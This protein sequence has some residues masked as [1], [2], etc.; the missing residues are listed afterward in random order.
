MKEK[1]FITLTPGRQ[2]LED[3][4][5]CSSWQDLWNLVGSTGKAD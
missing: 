3:S 5:H 4:N 2:R 1:S